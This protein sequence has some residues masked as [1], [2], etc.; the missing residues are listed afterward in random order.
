MV[1]SQSW[2]GH[3][4]GVRFYKQIL[5]KSLTLRQYFHQMASKNLLPS[6]TVS[7]EKETKRQPRGGTGHSRLTKH[8]DICL[9]PTNRLLAKDRMGRVLL[10]LTKMYEVISSTLQGIRHKQRRPRMH[11]TVAYMRLYRPLNSKAHR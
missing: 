7:K 2:C 9:Y 3:S 5:I 4:H 10:Y 8:S 6:T 11:S 1:W